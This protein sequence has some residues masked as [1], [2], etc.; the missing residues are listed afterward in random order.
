[1]VQGGLCYA[2]GERNEEKMLGMNY[3]LDEAGMVDGTKGQVKTCTMIRTLGGAGGNCPASKNLPP[4]PCASLPATKEQTMSDLKPQARIG[5]C[6]GAQGGLNCC[7]VVAVHSGSTLLQI[8]G[9]SEGQ[10]AWQT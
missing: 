9:R 3:I 4:T 1:M 5:S 2:M 10:Q 8:C 6:G 7:T